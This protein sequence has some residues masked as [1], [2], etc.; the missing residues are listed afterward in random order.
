MHEQSQDPHM[1]R[2]VRGLYSYQVGQ[3]AA[4]GRLLLLVFGV[5]ALVFWG[6]L[7]FNTVAALARGF[8]RAFLGQ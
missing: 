3:K 2:Q 4:V 8:A 5:S 1:A 6:A 7:A